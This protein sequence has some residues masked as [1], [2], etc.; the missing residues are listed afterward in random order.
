MGE[1][2]RGDVGFHVTHETFVQFQRT[3]RDTPQVTETR[4]AG[5]KVVHGQ[6]N[7]QSMHLV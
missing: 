2:L 3:E 4:I 6:A 7:A 5:A 1:G